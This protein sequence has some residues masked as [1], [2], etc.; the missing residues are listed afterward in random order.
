MP[1]AYTIDQLIAVRRQLD[2]GVTLLLSDDVAFVKELSAAD[3]ARF[4]EE[5]GEALLESLHSE[6]PS[7][8]S[9]LLNAY[10][11]TASSPQ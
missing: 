7:P 9:F 3:R 4:L 10:Q 8:A 2:P 6:D 11:T 1:V 5:F